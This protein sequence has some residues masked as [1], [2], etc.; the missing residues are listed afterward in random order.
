MKPNI[1]PE[2]RRQFRIP[3]AYREE[4]RR[5]IDDLV[6]YKLI[7]PSISPYSNPV[8]L[9]PKPPRPDGSYAGLRF[10]F[11]GRSIN[12]AIVFDSHM[13]PRVEEIIDRIAI[14]KFEAERAGKK[15]MPSEQC[16]SR[17]TVR[18]ILIPLDTTLDV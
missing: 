11:D 6:K 4:L 10:V 13:I 8:F 5:T 16:Y 9:V 3:E 2:S 17:L 18:V 15:R 14:L 1:E 12:R 7:E